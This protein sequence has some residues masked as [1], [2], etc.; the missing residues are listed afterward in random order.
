MPA[1]EGAARRL[2]TARS[3]PPRRTMPGHNNPRQEEAPLMNAIGVPSCRCGRASASGAPPVAAPAA[4]VVTGERNELAAGDR[5]RTTGGA[6]G[7]PWR[8]RGGRSVSSYREFTQHFRAGWV[9]TTPRDLGGVR[10]TSLTSWRASP[11]STP[12]RRSRASGSPTSVRPWWRGAGRPGL[13]HRAIVWQDRRTAE[14]CAQLEA[15]GPSHSCVSAPGWCRPLLQRHQVRWLLADPATTA[16]TAVVGAAVCRSTATWRSARSTRGSSGSSRT[17]PRMSPTSAT[18]AGRCCSTSARSPGT[19]SW[20]RCSACRSARSR[21]SCHRRSASPSPT[22]P[23]VCR[24]G[25]RSVASPVT[26]RRRSSVR[27]ACGRDGEEHLRHGANCQH[28]ID[29]PAADARAVLDHRRMATADGTVARPG[30]RSSSPVP[31]CNGCVM[32]RC[33]RLAAELSRSPTVGG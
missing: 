11:S 3:R 8:R 12:A 15:D 30:G 6:P 14:R 17:V 13:L 10:T 29:L 7:L 26:N 27:R 18:P 33:D 23:P 19:T 1:P 2:S 4:G 5:R 22:V 32:A 16:P 25:S 28:R 31:P 9:D 21:P 20:P 24:Q